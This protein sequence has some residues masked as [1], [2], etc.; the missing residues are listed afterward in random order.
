MLGNFLSLGCLGPSL[1]ASGLLSSHISCYLLPDPKE[2]PAWTVLSLDYPPST[3][4]PLSR[5]PTDPIHSL[6]PHHL[7][8]WLKSLL[9][10]CLSLPSDVVMFS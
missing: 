4:N 3:P 8:P 7:S 9:G 5:R 6:D 1:M 10:P 2:I